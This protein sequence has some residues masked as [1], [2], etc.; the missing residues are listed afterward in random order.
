MVF[1]NNAV[2]CPP[3]RPIRT[4]GLGAALLRNNAVH[5]RVTGIAV[6]DRRFFDGGTPG[7]AF[8]DANHR[9]F[10][11]KPGSALLGRADANSAPPLDFNATKRVLPST[12][13]PTRRMDSNGIQAGP[14][15]PDSSAEG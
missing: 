3:T 2:Y 4:D 1:C 15:S 13:A 6:D 9:D 12:W 10:W 11:P 5:G 7:S 8:V 14:S